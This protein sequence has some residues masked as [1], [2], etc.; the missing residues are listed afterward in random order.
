MMKKTLLLRKNPWQFLTPHNPRASQVYPHAIPCGAS[1][2]DPNAISLPP[3]PL[4]ISWWNNWTSSVRL[5]RRPKSLQ[6]PSTLDRWSTSNSKRLEHQL[7]NT[8][9]VCCWDRC[10]SDGEKETKWKATAENHRE[11]ESLIDIMCGKWSFLVSGLASS[12][13][14]SS[15]LSGFLWVQMDAKE[16]VRSTSWGVRANYIH[17]L[18][19]RLHCMIK[20]FVIL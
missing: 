11:R 13:H 12:A 20:L 19:W 3:P 5:Q 17:K 7:Y 8:Q 2:V 6:N 16:L 9:L 15:E 18:L 14:S 10:R 1:E 4:N